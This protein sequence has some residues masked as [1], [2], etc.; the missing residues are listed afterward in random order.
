[1]KTGFSD[2]RR[3]EKESAGVLLR[4][5]CYLLL[6]LLLSRLFSRLA[7]LAA[8]SPLDF[9]RFLLPPLA[10]VLPLV[11]F[12]LQG[13]RP[14]LLCTPKRDSVPRALP[15]LPL[16]LGAVMLCAYGTALAMDA[17][18]LSVS[19]GGVAGQGFFPDL[20]LNCLLPAALE[21]LFF[22]GLILS[23]LCQKMAGRGA[24]WLSAVIFALAHGSLYQLPYA[25]VGGVFLSLAAVVGGSVFVPF[26]F[27]FLNN[28][29]SLV[30]QYTP[31][32][33]IGGVI[34]PLL[35]GIIAISAL[36]AFLSIKMRRDTPSGAGMRALFASPRE[37]GRLVL[38]A[39]FASPLAFYL[40]PMLILTIVRVLV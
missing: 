2:T 6:Y 13:E 24:I 23:L 34:L 19:G 18:G 26:L 16:F 40:I 36:A 3:E 12:C 14:L 1:M 27:H 10:Y 35:Y 25:F 33:G 17:L 4:V 28:F 20:I 15:L 39:T 29:L 31:K 37:C 21:E 5:F 9:L 11:F 38:H 8:G 7:G 22:R 32:T 30:L